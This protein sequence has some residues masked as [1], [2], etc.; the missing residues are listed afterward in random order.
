MGMN[1]VSEDVM[2]RRSFI[3][4]VIVFIFSMTLL[5]GCGEW[6][7]YFYSK[8][9]CEKIAKKCLKEYFGEEFIIRGIYSEY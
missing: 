1:K 4:V 7:Q 9:R 8:A 6:T 3:S 5:V 2:K